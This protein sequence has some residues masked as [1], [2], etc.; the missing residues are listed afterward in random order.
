M[1]NKSWLLIAILFT[2][3][4][5][6]VWYFNYYQKRAELVMPQ[7]SQSS[8]TAKITET[9]PELLSET[10]NKQITDQLTEP[11]QVTITEL[12]TPVLNIEPVIATSDDIKTASPT[13]V[14]AQTEQIMAANIDLEKTTEIKLEI[15]SEPVIELITPNNTA[16]INKIIIDDL[17]AIEAGDFHLFFDVG[18]VLLQSSG[19][20]AAKAVGVSNMFWYTVKHKKTPESAE[21][22]ARLF[23]FM[24]FCTKKPRGLALFN[25]QPMPHLMCRWAK[26]QINSKEFIDT[27]LSYKTQAQTF[28]KSD[29][30]KNLVLGTLNLFEP[31]TICSIQR[32][33]TKMVNFFEDCCHAFPNRVCILSNWDKES[34]LLIR[35]QFPE[36]FNAIAKDH[37]FFSGDTGHLKPEADT[38]D[39]IIKKL[40]LNP[41]ACILIDDNKLNIEVAQ[42]LGWKTVLYTDAD[43][44]ISEIKKITQ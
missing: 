26:G 3:F 38:F 23:E 35:K 8:Q 22:Q 1:K 25:N 4:G 27:V 28:F 36:I 30:E 6:V 41:K 24:D 10:I 40:N 34:A 39:Y 16:E 44:A 9:E 7:I 31:N 21:I 2:T 43:T 5:I 32:P 37:I 11:V 19:P 20:T 29:E 12:T 13:P 14:I 17:N 42:S 18:Q 15:K 33:I